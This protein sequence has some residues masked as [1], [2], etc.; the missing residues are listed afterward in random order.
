MYGLYHVVYVEAD[1][2]SIIYAVMIEFES[3]VLLQ[4]RT[5]VSKLF[6]DC[7]PFLSSEIV[8]SSGDFVRP[9][10][11]YAVDL[12]TVYLQYKLWKILEDMPEAARLKMLVKVKSIRPKLVSIWNTIKGGTDVFS[13]FMKNVKPDGTYCVDF[14]NVIC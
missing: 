5:F 14:L 11:K 2:N 9:N 13:R 12:E 1:T 10:Y 7:F 6:L 4:Y 3:S 8:A